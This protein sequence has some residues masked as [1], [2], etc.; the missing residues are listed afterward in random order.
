VLSGAYGFALVDPALSSSSQSQKSIFTHDTTIS[1]LH[2]SPFV[3][4]LGLAFMIPPS[5]TT[6]MLCRGSLFLNFSHFALCEFPRMPH[7][8]HIH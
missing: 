1:Q 8:P 5:T 6:T 7:V 2:G 3:A 4:C